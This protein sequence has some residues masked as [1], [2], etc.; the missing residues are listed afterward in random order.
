MDAV[1][2]DRAELVESLLKLH[3]GL[4]RIDKL[5]LRNLE[6]G[7]VIIFATVQFRPG[8]YRRTARSCVPRSIKYWLSI[9]P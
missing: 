2:I 7:N 4:D 3:E 9:G 5:L 8:S 1:T 6:A